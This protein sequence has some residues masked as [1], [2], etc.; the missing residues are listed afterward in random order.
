MLKVLVVCH[1]AINRSP[2]CGVV[3]SKAGLAVRIAACKEYGKSSGRMS[4]TKKMRESMEERGYDLTSHRAH[5]VTQ[6][7]VD[8]AEIILHMDGGNRKRLLTKFPD[9]KN[10]LRC[11]AEWT[12]D[13]H[14]ER[15]PDPN[16]MSRDNPEFGK[17]VDLI[18]KASWM[19]A[20]TEGKRL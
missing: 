7:D 15:I 4:A 12:I 20:R 17:I 16:F 8:W 1:G 9:A 14:M 5:T 2:A 3:L 10:K 11:L 6:D 13:P 18:V 19:F